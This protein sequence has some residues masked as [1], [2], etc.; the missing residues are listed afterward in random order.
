MKGKLSENQITIQKF[1]HK[2]NTTQ[3]NSSIE[4][5]KIDN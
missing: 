1:W 5:N 3:A 2:R 4:Q